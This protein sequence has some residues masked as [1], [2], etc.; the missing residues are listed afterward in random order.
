[1]ARSAAL[2][3]VFAL[4]LPLPLW[5][6]GGADF[7]ARLAAD[8]DDFAALV[9]AA[10]ALNQ[11]MAKR[12][13]G[14]LPLIDGL[15]DTDENKALWAELAPRALAHARRAHALRPESVEAAA[16]LANAYM[17]YASSLGIIRA[18][19]AGSAGEY[20]VHANRLVELDPA[21]D[22]GLGDYLL[23]SYYLV[24]P[25]PVGDSEEALRH[26]ERAAELSPDSVRN[27]Y[28]LAVYWAREGDEDRAR[29][30]FDRALELP[31][32]EHT[33][34]LF[35]DFMKRESKRARAAL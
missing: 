26:Y 23:A 29:K 10:N 2:L 35:C 21:Y 20:R 19:L 15:Q 18:I 13:N 32:T 5:A 27:H 7:E 28:G 22:D 34:R 11:E 6:A 33:E 12:T 9:G 30:H 17:F 3:L 31:C 8:P 25:W 24:A 4:S 16:A 14:N 1:M